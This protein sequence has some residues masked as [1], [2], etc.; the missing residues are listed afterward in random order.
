MIHGVIFRHLERGGGRM[1]SDVPHRGHYRN[2]IREISR[3]DRNS[4]IVQ[5]FTNPW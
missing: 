3:G 5:V 4:G 2:I 1:K